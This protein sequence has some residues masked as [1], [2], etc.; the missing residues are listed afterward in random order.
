MSNRDSFMLKFFYL[1]CKNI[2]ELNL[3]RKPENVALAEVQKIDVFT[4]A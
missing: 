3:T 1:L 4:F 2:H